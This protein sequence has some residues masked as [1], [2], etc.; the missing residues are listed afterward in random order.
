MRRKLDNE[1]CNIF[2]KY[3]NYGGIDI[4]QNQFGGVNEKD[5][6]FMDNDQILDARAPSRIPEDREGWDIDFERVVKG[7][8]YVCPWGFE[9]SSEPV[10]FSAVLQ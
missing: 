7:F 8:L 1:R 2:L 9:C 3:L 6:K 10:R 5:L 4:K